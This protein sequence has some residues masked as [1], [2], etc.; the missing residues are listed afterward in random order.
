MDKEWSI[1]KAIMWG[2]L[3]G[4]AYTLARILFDGVQANP[5]FAFGQLLGGIVGGA[6]LFS[7]TAAARNWRVRLK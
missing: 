1:W 5:H 2:A 4:G 3:L 7:V 6:F